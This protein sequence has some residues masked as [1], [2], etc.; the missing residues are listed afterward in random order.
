M[1]PFHAPKEIE[2][3]TPLL[4]HEQIIHKDFLFS[5]QHN[6]HLRLYKPKSNPSSTK[7]LP[8]LYHLHGGGF[9]FG[10]LTY[11]HHQ[12]ICVRLG[13]EL[14]A[15]VIEPDHRLAPEDRLTAALDDATSAL[16]W[17]QDKA[18]HDGDD[19]NMGTWLDGVDFDRV[20][21]LGYSSGGN[22]GHHLAV[23]FGGSGA[24][25]LALVRVRGY[26]L[27]SPFFGGL[28]K[29][30]CEEERPFEG[31]WNLEMYDS[32]SLAEV[33][34]DPILVIVG[35]DEILRDRVKDYSTKLEEL[36]KNIEYLELEGEQHGYFT[37]RPTSATAARVIE[38]IKFFMSDK[39]WRLSVPIGATQDHPMVNPFGPSSPSLAEVAL[40][41]ILVI[42]RADEIL[43]D[44]VKDYS[45]KL[46]ELGKNIEYLELEG[47]QHG[48][49]TD[50]PTSATADRVI[51]TVKFF[52]SDK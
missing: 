45:T 27:L 1:A 13:N 9:C 34:L 15:L 10:S 17:L 3:K 36:G 42:V 29:T 20:F 50:R 12:N 11:P 46:E 25:E 52:M 30:R 51:E 5:E 40:D 33:A 43:R 8:I 32:P 19:G 6:L 35:A 16:K 18:M 22:L 7:K 23:R 49:F 2:F 37:D 38:T 28:K 31:F 14:Q 24:A 4:D 21:V 41:P 26:V 44:R 47:E 48:Y 39:F